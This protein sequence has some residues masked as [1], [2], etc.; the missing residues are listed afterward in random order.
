MNYYSI[1]LPDQPKTSW[2]LHDLV[3]TLPK[4]K[5]AL[6]A[7]FYRFFP[8]PDAEVQMKA[9]YQVLCCPK[10]GKYDAD[11][12]FESGFEEPVAIRFKQD[13]GLTDD[14]VFVLNDKCL[15]VLKK[16]GVAG[17]E[18]KPIGKS[19][20][21]PLRVTALVE[22][23]K[24]LLQPSKKKCPE[25]GRAADA[26]AWIWQ[27]KQISLPKEPNTFFS[28]RMSSAALSF[29]DRTLFIT[30][31]VLEVLKKG[32]IKGPHC[33]R[34]WTD[35]ELQRKEQEQK[36]GKNWRPAEMTVFLKGK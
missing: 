31:D 6:P 4:H 9:R 18:T 24:G 17:F 30:Q 19:G 29:Q 2:V 15:Q 23:V 10:C 26:G 1:C 14:R 20:W 8:P 21:H 3:K 7:S 34:L 5:R 25:C 22:S 27:I 13:M 35:E 33:E 16:A 11:A 32:G 28:T 36:K 12:I